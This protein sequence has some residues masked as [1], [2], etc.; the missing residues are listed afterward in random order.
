MTP[1]SL[2]DDEKA[3]EKLDGLGYK[4]LQAISYSSPPPM[5]NSLSNPHRF[6]CSDGNKY[7]LKSRCQNGLSAELIAGRIG[8]KL[9]AAP[10][11]AVVNLDPL[12]VENIPACQHLT[13]LVVGV[14]EVPDSINLKDIPTLSPG[15]TFPPRVIDAASRARVVAFH[16]WFGFSDCQMFVGLGNGK[17]VT[18]DLGGCLGDV[19]TQTNPTL[20]VLD[21]PGLP[22]N[23]GSQGDCVNAAVEAIES[24]TD[25]DILSAA[26]AMPGEPRW[27][28]D[29]PQRLARAKWLA[30][31]RSKVRGVL[32]QWK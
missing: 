3:L 24:L 17:V 18:A 20:T 19:V 2:F 22:S 32:E 26:A 10:K 30:G 4:V 6:V 9:A 1:G 7:W 12:L 13:G 21:I 15:L 29:R 11:V 23:H 31:R 27:S 28:G 5:P 16:T 8:Q 14:F 25:D